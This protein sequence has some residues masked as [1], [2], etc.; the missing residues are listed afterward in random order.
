MSRPVNL[1]SNNWYRRMRVGPARHDDAG[2][3]Q[4]RATSVGGAGRCAKSGLLAL[5]AR[6][7]LAALA[8]AQCIL[9]VSGRFEQE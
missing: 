9:R 7:Y 5:Q 2:E 6:A 4:N 8:A 3:F 1:V